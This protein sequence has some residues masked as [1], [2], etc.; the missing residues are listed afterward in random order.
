M[1]ATGRCGRM[2]VVSDPV[3]YPVDFWICKFL[4]LTHSDTVSNLNAVASM[5]KRG[6]NGTYSRTACIVMLDL[7][8]LT[9]LAERNLSDKQSKEERKRWTKAYLHAFRRL[10]WVSKIHGCTSISTPERLSNM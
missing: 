4:H 7:S 10:K 5:S 1:V 8:V 2:T 6:S 9:T 3:I